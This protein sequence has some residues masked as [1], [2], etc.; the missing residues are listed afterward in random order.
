VRTREV[1]LFFLGFLTLT[2]CTTPYLQVI[3]PQDKTEVQAHAARLECG[4]ASMDP[5][6]PR[7]ISGSAMNVGGGMTY[8]EGSV[9]APEVDWVLY[10]DCMEKLGYKIRHTEIF[11]FLGEFPVDVPPRFVRE[12]QKA[13][14]MWIH[15]EATDGTTTYAN[16]DTIRRD[17]DLVTMWALLDFKTI[18]TV[19]GS[20]ILSF[21]VQD[22]YDCTEERTRRLA[23]TFFSGNMGRG[24]MVY[25]NSSKDKWEQDPQGSIKYDLWKLACGKT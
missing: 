12:G 5:T 14:W 11:W 9:S 23:V 1:I 21:K 25:S 10:E 20:S 15:H 19:E 13:E 6:T 22:E 3:I 24:K 16:P 7:R 18:Q 8:S 2:G 4:K 17:G